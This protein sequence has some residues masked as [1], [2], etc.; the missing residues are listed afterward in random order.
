MSVVTHR[1]ESI[2]THKAKETTF[3]QLKENITVDV[4]IV[5]AGITG[6]ST[7]SY[8]MNRGLKVAIVEA[9]HVGYGVSGFNSGHLTSMLLD[10]KYSS[11]HH[12]FG[13]E[14]TQLVGQCQVDAI[15]MIEANI[16]Q[17]GMDCEFKR[18]PGFLYAEQPDQVKA[19]EK[20][21]NATQQ[22]NV[23]CELIDHAPLPFNTHKAILLPEQA[24]FHPLKYVQGLAQAV[25]A[26]DELL[27]ENTHVVGIDQGE[28]CVVKTRSGTITANKVVLGTHTP[29]G[30]WPSI[31][32]RLEP[33]RSY[34]IGVRVNDIIA[35][36]LYWDMDEPYH[37]MRL[38]EDENGP[39]LIIGGEDHKTGEKEDTA[40]CFKGLEEY[41]HRHY[42]VRSIDYHWSAQLYDPVDGLPY[43]GPTQAAPNVYIATGFTGEGLTGGTY[44]GKIIADAILGVDNAW[45]A[46]YRPDRVKPL[47]S[48]AGFISENVGTVA[49]FV[50]DRLKPSEA[51]TE[52]E[53]PAGKGC[54]LMKEGKKV[55]AYKDESGKVHLMSPVCTHM[56][57]HV[58]WNNAEKS[59]DCPCHGGRYDATG[60]VIDGP[61]VKN[62]DKI[63]G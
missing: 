31:Q 49:H 37:Y 12:D 9:N 19:L 21:F 1:S 2:W 54:I 56:G 24:R 28:Q 46:V 48:A 57:C 47:A 5:G 40:T 30:L 41:A 62:L 22:A 25:A 39:L 6:L 4:A 14:K 27:F 42:D 29:I 55:A 8:L 17:Y 61:P 35:D 32:T 26:Q 18:I 11:I 51:Q 10:M 52:A 13:T 45:A 20:E 50:G 53:I 36:G 59:W 34:I 43:I 3:P 7:A 23:P 63:E 58:N 33:I 16:R 60:H 15:N 44:A 38:T